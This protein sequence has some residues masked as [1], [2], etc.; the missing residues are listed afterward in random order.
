[1]TRK[2]FC[3]SLILACVMTGCN[4]PEKK[5]E[6]Y[7]ATFLDL[8]DITYIVYVNEIIDIGVDKKWKDN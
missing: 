4:A 7:Q 3:L 5:Q 1:M 2:I 8:F 6:R